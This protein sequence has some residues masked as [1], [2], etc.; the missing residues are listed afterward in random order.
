MSDPSANTKTD[1]E[2]APDT[3]DGKLDLNKANDVTMLRMAIERWGITP[4]MAREYAVQAGELVE[5]AK[6][7]STPNQQQR[8]GQRALGL[9]KDMVAQQQ[10][11]EHLE[12]KNERLDKGK[13]TESVDIRIGKTIEIIDRRDLEARRKL[14]SKETDDG[15]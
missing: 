14:E 7:L 1:A 12:I 13:P 11:D 4:G 5:N 6:R 3:R 10:A 2:A 8:A 9:I 15:E